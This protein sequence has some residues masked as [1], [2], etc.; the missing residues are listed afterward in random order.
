MYGIHAQGERIADRYQVVTVLG[1]GSMGTTYAAVD[2]QT[3]QRVAIKVVSL[4][5][6]SEW[7]VLDLF[8]REARVLATLQH[9]G[10][11]QYVDYFQLDTPDDRRFYLVQELVEGESLEKLR[12]QGWQPT[13]E[14]VKAIAFQ[15][16]EIL[17]YLHG[18]TP[19]V[20]HRDLKPDNLIRDPNG[21]I[22]LV[23]FGAVQDIYRTTLSHSGTFVGTVGYMPPEQF[24]G[25]AQ[26]ASD[27]YSLGATLV[28]LLCGQSPAELP[29]KRMKLDFRSE[30]NVSRPF[31]DWLTKMLEPALE[32]RF[33]NAVVA[34]ETLTENLPLDIVR[35]LQPNLNPQP[36]HSQIVLTKTETDLRAEIPSGTWWTVGRFSLLVVNLLWGAIA[37]ILELFMLL[38][39]IIIAFDPTEDFGVKILVAVF[40]ALPIWILAKSTHVVWRRL[41]HLKGDETTLEITPTTLKI[42]SKFFPVEETAEIPLDQVL[43]YQT[44]H[45]KHLEVQYQGKETGAG[46]SRWIY[47]WE[48]SKPFRIRF[49]HSL[50]PE[51]QDW[52]VHEVNAFREEVLTRP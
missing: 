46:R 12:S 25:Q 42:Q 34:Q 47:I 9:P 2:E 24:R 10:I 1:Q 21:R 44:H 48:T 29:Q 14:E 13:E 31:G 19:P 51:E 8:E 16:L 22:V 17:T 7:K 35:Q 36:P 32:D 28:F 5:Q 30:I 3:R 43:L 23:D 38:I 20:I 37:S 4:R 6:V 50:T 40:L 52:L 27:L 33:A 11:P 41:R 26:L 39:V 15:V 18:L 45:P 49:G